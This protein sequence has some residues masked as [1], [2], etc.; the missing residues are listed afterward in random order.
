MTGRESLFHGIAV[1]IDDEIEKP[2]SSIKKITEAIVGA[3]CHVVTLKTLPNEASVVNLRE[4]AF[5]VLDW[6]LGAAA[7]AE[8]GGEGIMPPETLTQE[9]EDAVIAFLKQLKET[10]FA[11]VFIFTNESVEAIE[12]RLRAH[13]DLYNESDP[14]HIL[15]K[16]KSY[17]IE[18]GV[19][20]VLDDWV[21]S[22]PSAFV[23]K[24]W[25]RQYEKA[26]NELF[27][28]FYTKSTIW[29]LILWETFKAD[30]V[31][32]ASLLGEIIGGNLASRM[33]PLDCDLEP[34]LKLLSGLD[35][36]DYREAVIRVLEGER[37][38]K[39]ERLDDGSCEPGDIF[40]LPKG[41]FLINIRPLCDCVPRNGEPMDSLVLYTLEGSKKSDAS[42]AKSFKP[43][44]GLIEEQDNQA[45]V[46]PVLDGKALVFNFKEIHFKTWGE[47]KNQR[48]G[49][50]LPPFLTRLQQR[51]AANLQRPGLTRLPSTLFDGVNGA[52]PMAE[53]GQS[54]DSDEGNDQ[55]TP[56]RG[57]CLFSWPWNRPADNGP[58]R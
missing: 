54:L 40:K 4:V 47:V 14:S 7:I 5:L 30:G 2:E 6:N 12:D 27:L 26:K 29:P 41:V 56:P 44:F 37:F 10:R 42:L 1:V 35:K 46:F 58:T 20:S 21:S 15:V 49:R 33:S 39:K 13:P 43:D 45:V 31:P 36:A 22:A 52:T 57:G 28:D 11:P 25:E 55:S 50:L 51:F 34:F 53:A 24:S 3:G 8:I 17:V 23:L 9:N 48:V 16:S 18:K 19:F 32:P 38:L